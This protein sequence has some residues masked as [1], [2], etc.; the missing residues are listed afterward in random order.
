MRWLCCGK[1]S[2]VSSDITRTHQQSDL[3]P[4]EQ[5]AQ[6]G[7]PLLQ[8][9]V[10]CTIAD[11]SAPAKTDLHSK[12]KDILPAVSIG[13]RPSSNEGSPMISSAVSRQE[14]TVAPSIFYDCVESLPAESVCSE[15]E[16]FP[17]VEPGAF[18]NDDPCTSAAIVAPI[19]VTEDS[20]E[21]A[22]GE[23][24]S[25]QCSQSS[26]G[27]GRSSSQHL[28]GGEIQAS[29]EPIGEDPNATSVA[30]SSGTP[31]PAVPLELR[32]IVTSYLEVCGQWDT[33]RTTLSAIATP[34]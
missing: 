21:H 6:H 25:V 28:L 8:P 1:G 11:A 10:S 17:A 13:T 7:C 23:E 3:T 34:A 29:A 4:S 12:V 16:W 5:S 9:D 32:S 19:T 20:S 26:E 22:A 18:P 27:C 33:C 14:T 30:A 24:Q 15:E 31:G 2:Q